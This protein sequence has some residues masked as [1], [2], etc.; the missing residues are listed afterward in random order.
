MFF[1]QMVKGITI[2][3]FE[4]LAAVLNVIFIS[5]KIITFTRSAASFGY[6]NTRFFAYIIIILALQVLPIFL[7]I[8]HRNFHKG[9]ALRAVFYT[10]SASLFIGT[11]C[12][13]VIF[14]GFLNYTFR[15]GDFV[16]I[17]VFWNMPHTGGAVFCL[18]ISALYFL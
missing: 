2:I 17:N 6:I 14:K 5:T 18:I 12:D 9:Q 11:L 13:I 4:V 15:E 3:S 16:F 7:L 1:R 10:L 8:N